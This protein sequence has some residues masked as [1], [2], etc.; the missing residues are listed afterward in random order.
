MSSVSSIPVESKEKP[1][2]RFIFSEKSSLIDT[3]QSY[4]KNGF[5]PKFD[6]GTPYHF[7][8]MFIS[9]VDLTKF[10]IL[11]TVQ[12]I[13][14]TMAVDHSS[15]THQKKEYMTYTV[16]VEAKD[17]LGNTIRYTHEFEGKIIEQ[18][19]QIQTTLNP[20]TGEHIQQYHQSAPRTSYTIEWDKKKAQ[21]ILSNEKYFGEDTINITNSN[22]VR[23]TGHFPYGE[24]SMRTG[25][26]MEDFLNLTY[27]ALYDKARTTPSPQVEALKKRQ[28]PYS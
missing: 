13:S 7:E 15:P 19:K 14:R 9:Q 17:W 8:K 27:Q 18:T 22:E 2:P 12:N 4:A 25:F 6:F 28:N 24:P 21:D 26:Q 20:Q 16:D 5:E 11:V 23:Y 1:K 3:Y 10:P